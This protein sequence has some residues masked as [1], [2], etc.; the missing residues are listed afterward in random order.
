MFSFN[1]EFGK[2]AMKSKVKMSLPL[3]FHLSLMHTDACI[4]VG[5]RTYY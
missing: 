1:G 5:L 4:G 2:L 3:M